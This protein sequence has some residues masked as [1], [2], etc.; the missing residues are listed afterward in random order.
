MSTSVKVSGGRYEEGPQQMLLQSGTVVWEASPVLAAL[1]SL[2]SA[3]VLALLCADF[4]SPCVP[5]HLFFLSHAY[6]WS[7]IAN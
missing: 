6:R 5:L 4:T 7:L 3:I 2:A 1:S